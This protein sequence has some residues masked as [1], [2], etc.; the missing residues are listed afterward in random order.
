MRI[1]ILSDL[2]L[3]IWRDQGSNINLDV[4]GPDIVMLAGDIASGAEGVRW[5]GRTFAGISVMYIHGNHE[6]YGNT[7]EK[8]Q[9]EIAE[10]CS[11]TANVHFLNCGEFRHQNVRVLG[12]TLWTDFCLFGD[13]RQ[14]ACAMAV[15]EVMEDYRA[16]RLAVDDNRRLLPEDTARIHAVQK[17]WLAEGLDEEF[18]GPIVV[19]THMAPS[20]RSIAAKYAGHPVSAAFASRLDDLVSRATI[21]IHGHMHYSFDYRVGSCRA[22]CN[23]L[24]YYTAIGTPENS[25]FDPNFI[26]EV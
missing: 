16:I 4:S 10:A 20:M 9:R 18:D 2:R 15:Q 6:A 17:A 26:V 7:L 3:E 23:P 8:M 25:A 12:V 5:A 14:T 13:E 1:L 22:I 24:G 11:Q 21:W 19:V